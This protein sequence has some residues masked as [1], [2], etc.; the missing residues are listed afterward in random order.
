MSMGLKHLILI[1]Q[2]TFASLLDTCYLITLN[3]SYSSEQD[4]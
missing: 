2:F 1:A 3:I 4:G